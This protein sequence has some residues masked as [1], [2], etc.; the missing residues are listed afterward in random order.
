MIAT[1]HFIAEK[2]QNYCWR[3]SKVIHP[4]V[5]IKEYQQIHSIQNDTLT[6]FTHGRLEA[7]KGLDMIIR[8]FQRI[9]KEELKKKKE[10]I[11]SVIPAQA[12]IQAWI[13]ERKDDIELTGLDSRLHGSDE[14][15]INLIIFGTGSLESELRKQGID[16]RPF[17]RESTFPELL[18]G[19]YGH[20]LSVYCS[21]IDGFGI[22]P[23]ESQMAWFSTVILDRAG[24]RET[25]VTNVTGVPVWYLVESEDE[26]F[27]TICTYMNKKVFPKKMSNVNFYHHKDYFSLS[28]LSSD[29]LSV[30]NKTED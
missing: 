29:L 7:G 26:I 27:S 1:S 19:K 12:G 16:V 4:I 15:R 9:K 18:T 25:I 23:L 14:N 2:V 22:A 5:E 24:A 20:I 6:L 21:E 10:G 8:V 13:K 3:E 30:I 28:R 17:D 11:L